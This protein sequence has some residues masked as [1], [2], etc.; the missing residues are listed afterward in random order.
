MIEPS[1]GV[2]TQDYH[3]SGRPHLHVV[4]CA[5]NLA[6]LR[7]DNVASASFPDRD[8]DEA[9]GGYI[10]A[11]QMDHEG[12]T[13]WPVRNEASDWDPVAEASLLRHTEEDHDAGVRAFFPE[14][15]DATKFHQDVQEA[16]D[17]GALQ[18]Y[19]AKYPVKFSDSASE[20]WLNDAHGGDALA[21]SDIG[22]SDCRMARLVR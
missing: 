19:L 12:N 2:F 20:D 1:P 22:C 18:A 3:G 5:E 17:D 13:P 4:I 15:L 14:L 6:A 9:L 11:C 21:K 7:L 8:A 16:T 10:A